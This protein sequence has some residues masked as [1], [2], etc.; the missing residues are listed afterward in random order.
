MTYAR[1]YEYKGIERLRD[2]VLAILARDLN[3][4]ETGEL[5]LIRAETS[6]PLADIAEFLGAQKP[7][8]TTPCV[9]VEPDV[10]DDDEVGN[11]KLDEGYI[12]DITIVA[13]PDEDMERVTRAIMRYK[14]AVKNVLWSMPVA[15]LL[16][17]YNTK[18]ARWEVRG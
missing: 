2:N 13:A 9:V 18:S 15:D 10:D 5:A 3:E 8:V 11:G 6:E 12:L 7:N 17:G 16:A 4:P 1:R 14:R